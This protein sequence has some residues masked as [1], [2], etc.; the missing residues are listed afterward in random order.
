MIIVY[1][2]YNTITKRLATDEEAKAMRPSPAGGGVEIL[3]LGP[4]TG[5][6]CWLAAEGWVTEYGQRTTMDE[7]KARIKSLSDAI[8]DTEPGYVDIK[9]DPV[10]ALIWEHAKPVSYE[11]VD[12]NPIIKE[13]QPMGG[14]I[15]IVLFEGV[16]HKYITDQ[17]ATPYLY[18]GLADDQ[19]K[20]LAMKPEQPQ[21][22]EQDTP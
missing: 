8:K 10:L 6:F 4:E 14:Q 13:V 20:Y 21:A 5:K 19:E 18:C 2:F 11:D 15:W 1:R 9:V 7:M 22:P 3:A 12:F 17:E 16:A